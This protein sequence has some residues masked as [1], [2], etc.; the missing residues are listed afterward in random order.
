MEVFSLSQKYILAHDLG[1]S[2][3]KASLYDENGILKG[4][5]TYNYDTFYPKVGWAEQDSEDWWKAVC[6]STKVILEKARVNPEDVAVISFSG[7][8]MGAL[9]LDSE[10]KPLRRSIIWA[11]QR[12]IKETDFL[13]DVM[14]MDKV[15]QITGTSIAPNYT[16]EKILWIK[17][18]EE[19]IYN[20]T[21]TF[22]NA[23]DY[24]VY[25]LTGKFA[26][27]YSDASGTNILDI[28]KKVWSEDIIKAAGIDRSKLPEL[29]ASTDII[30]YISH[31]VA[32]EIGLSPK[33]AVVIG[34]GD[35]SCATVGAGA[36]EDG[37][38]YN[39][40][41]S[42]SWISVTRKE[43]LYD[44]EQR[45][46][47]LCHLNPELY[48]AIGTMQ[49][50]GGSFQ[51][52]RDT[53]ALVE[54]QAAEIAGLDAYQ[55]MSA[56]AASAVPGS[57]SLIFL[58]YLL[59]ERCPY[60]N[61]DAKGAFVGLTRGHSREDI[62]RSV[63][64]GVVFNLRVILDLFKK[65][66]VNVSEITAIGGGIRSDLLSQIMADIYEVELLRLVVLEEATSFGAAVAGGVG[67]G[68]FN[69]FNE[70]K[71][72]IKIAD[73]IKPIERNSRQYSKLYRIFKEAY[74]A[75][76]GVY[77]SLTKLQD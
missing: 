16:L 5:S 24:I 63:L 25:R 74:Q 22:V 10:G 26:T 29:Y 21:A 8:M 4:S 60:W 11:D 47:N 32:N 14:G 41:G 36:V 66:G 15:Y 72:I 33:T 23:K 38:I 39:Y 27:D 48:M 1:T 53:I 6:F 65:Q 31:Q 7:Q 70:V 13:K 61:P 45:T 50:A 73:R 54:K 17:N 57:N 46:F 77:E 40:Y 20:R 62:I 18:N 30:G 56:K 28:K 75:L 3:D 69:G 51:W 2:G 64:E 43:P 49:S 44:Q 42:S 19:S 67:V 55:L 76:L 34:G 68:I 71:K 9:P 35:G 37:N 12:A 58:P 52:I 59:G